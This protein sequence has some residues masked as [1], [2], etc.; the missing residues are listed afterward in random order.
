MDIRVTVITGIV[1]PAGFE[2]TNRRWRT[3]SSYWE[4]LPLIVE[5]LMRGPDGSFPAEQLD[6]KR[7]HDRGERR[8]DPQI[9][10]D[11]SESRASNHDLA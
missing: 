9:H 10:R 4:T 2:G 3:P 5:C 1:T 7:E 8:E 11:L 6:G